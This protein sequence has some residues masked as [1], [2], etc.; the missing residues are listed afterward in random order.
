MTSA[1]ALCEFTIGIPAINDRP[2][3]PHVFVTVDQ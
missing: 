3:N 1:S 2:R